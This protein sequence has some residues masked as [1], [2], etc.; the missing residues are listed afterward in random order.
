[1][2]KILHRLLRTNLVASVGS[3]VFIGAGGVIPFWWPLTLLGVFWFIFHFAAQSAPKRLRICFGYG[4][5]SWFVARLISISWFWTVY[6]FDW[7]G[8]D[9]GWLQLLA[10]GMYWVVAAFALA[11]GGGVM[12]VVLSWVNRLGRGRVS[13]LWVLPPLWV[14][15]EALGSFLFSIVSWAPGIV[16]NIGFSFGY[17]GYALAAHHP[18][19]LLAQW[20]GVYLLSF[21]LVTFSVVGVLTFRLF[22]R[23]TALFAVGAVFMLLVLVNHAPMPPNH[24]KNVRVGVVNTTYEANFLANPSGGRTRA[25]DMRQAL[26]EANEFSIDY[27]LLPEDSRVTNSF[28]SPEALMNWYRFAPESPAILVDSG[29]LEV[30]GVQ[31]LRAHIY[32]PQEN[33]I[34]SIDKQYLVP[35]GEFFPTLFVQILSWVGKRELVESIQSKVHYAPGPR[36]DASLFTTTPALI[37]CS[38]SV[39]PYA[40]ISKVKRYEPPLILHPLSHAWFNE[41]HLLWNQL[42]AML[43]VQAVWSGRPIVSAGNMSPGKVYYANGS[44]Q[45]VPIVLEKERYQ[46]GLIEL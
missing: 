17:V 2:P 21:V 34:D 16:P 15:A 46:I 33:T 32:D 43:R 27:L 36:K 20:G 7:L 11:L 39:F 41:P 9:S 18:L 44:Q 22:S 4:F 14:M 8:V 37:F 31:H 5:L 10:I 29:Y 12:L 24:T 38:E 28:G 3:G 35:Q 13:W 1:M 23:Q 19:L 6:P 45:T 25:T 26:R 42:D 30:A 40:T